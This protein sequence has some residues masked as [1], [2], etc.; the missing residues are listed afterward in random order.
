MRSTSSSR[1]PAEGDDTVR[2]AVSWLLG[3]NV[4]NLTLVGAAVVNGTGNALDNWLNGNS[5]ANVLAGGDGQD[6]VYGDLGNDTLQ[7]GNGRDILQG[8]D[9]ADAIDAGAGSNLLHGGLAADT[10]TGGA[11]NDLLAGGAG[12]DT[13][14][15]GA[16]ADLIAFNRGDGQDTVLASVG[17][18]NTLTLGGGIRHADIALRRAGNDLVVETGASE[19]VTLK[20]WYLAATNRHVVNLQTIVDATADWNPA[21]ADA[22]LNR[23]VARFDFTRVASQFDA[24]LAAN[25]TLTRWSVASALASAHVAGSDTAALGGDLAYQYGHGGSFAGIGWTGADA[26]L[27]SASFGTAAQSFQSAATLFSGTKTLR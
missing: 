13:I 16:G 14:A 11:G 20:D 10:L 5:A 3:A 19:F 17:T 8:G 15:T 7:G 12:N 4:E 26:V 1:T 23:R 6:L 2:S 21:S 25:P 9:G 27:A 24:A 22:L 18:D